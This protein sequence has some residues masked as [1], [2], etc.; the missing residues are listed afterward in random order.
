MSEPTS[1]V[2]VSG[3]PESACSVNW[4]SD[5]W[6][7]KHHAKH[8][9]EDFKAWWLSYYLDP[10]EYEDNCLEQHEYWVRCAFALQGWLAAKTPNPGPERGRADSNQQKEQET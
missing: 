9:T 10:T 5:A 2:P 1:A 7:A 8:L 3:T 4:L 6:F